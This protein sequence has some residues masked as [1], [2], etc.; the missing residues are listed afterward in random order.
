MLIIQV[1]RGNPRFLA[2]GPWFPGPG[3]LPPAPDP[4]PLAP[5]LGPGPQPP[6]PSPRPLTLPRPF[7]S[8][9]HV[10]VRIR[11]IKQTEVMF[12]PCWIAFTPARKQYLIYKASLSHITMVISMLR[13][14]LKWRVTY[15]IGVHNV[16]NSFSC[17]HEKMLGIL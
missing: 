7:I 5:G 13:L 15:W 9:S 17:R 4:H 2:P 14:S 1:A 10:C 12:T 6:A 3:P 16:L 8:D 11:R